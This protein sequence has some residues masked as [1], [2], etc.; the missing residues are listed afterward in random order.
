MTLFTLP[1]YLDGDLLLPQSPHTATVVPVFQ[2]SNWQ[3]FTSRI[4]LKQIAPRF[5]QLRKEQP[6]PASLNLIHRP[7][8]SQLSQMENKTCLSSSNTSAFNIHRNQKATK[9]LCESRT[10]KDPDFKM[11]RLCAVK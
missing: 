1:T 8:R 11:L 2:K 9:P 5:S 3:E 6:Q 7:P 10:D 4:L